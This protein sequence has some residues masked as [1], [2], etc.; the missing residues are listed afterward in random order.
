MSDVYEAKE[1][2]HSI[3]AQLYPN[4]LQGGEGTYVVSVYKVI[5]CNIAPVITRRLYPMTLQKTFCP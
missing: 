5:V 4:H 3:E 2:M 1:E